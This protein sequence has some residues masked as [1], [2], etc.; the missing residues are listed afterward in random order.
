MILAPSG[1]PGRGA[2]TSE[3]TEAR[4][5]WTGV[6]SVTLRAFDK[7]RLGPQRR[8]SFFT[9]ISILPAKIGPALDANSHP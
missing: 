3:G 7:L 2:L 5:V 1:R 6:Q 8:S 4:A 9:V